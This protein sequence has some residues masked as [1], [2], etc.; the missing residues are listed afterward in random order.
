M[1]KQFN[2]IFKGFSG[3]IARQLTFKQV[4]GKTI[5]TVFPDRSKVIYSPAQ[6]QERDRFRQAVAF[7]KVM[8][9]HQ[10]LK[11]SYALKARK[12]NLRSAYHAALAEFM[13]KGEIQAKPQKI[14]FDSSLIPYIK[15]KS[16]IKLYRYLPVSKVYDDTSTESASRIWLK[17]PA[18][19]DEIFV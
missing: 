9:S 11:D 3:S 2:P 15:V 16:R 6:L 7:A 13:C 14:R 12:L 5:F 19:A 8:I 17:Y 1:P 4:N 10:V 18:Y